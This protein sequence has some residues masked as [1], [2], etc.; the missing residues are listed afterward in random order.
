MLIKNG[1]IV[2]PLNKR[3]GKF[4]ILITGSKIKEIKK[5]IK[6]DDKE[7][8]DVEKKLVIP[9]LIDM[10]V[11]L[12]EPGREDI[13]TVESGT[14]AATSS[15]IT[16]LCAMPNTYPAMD[17]RENVKKLND[18]IEKDA[19]NN[20]FVIGA[21]TEKRQGKKL[22]DMKRMKSE[23]VV[24][25]SD[26][27]SSVE[28]K[29][30]MLE[31]LK[32]AE[33]NNLFLISHCEDKK[34]SKAGVVNEGIIAT[35]LG[36][37]GIPKKAEYKFVKR[38]I[39]LAKEANTRIHIAH[40]S[41]K[42]SVDIIRK[43][44]EEGIK[45]T[46]ETA[47]HYFSIDENAC[48]SYDTR[49]KMNPPLRSKEDL[50]AIKEALI[51]GTIDAI[52]SDH[53][54]HGKHEKE[55]EF[56]TAAFGIIGLETLLGLA[57]KLVDKKVL[58]WKR[59]VELTSVNPTKILGLKNKGSISVG[60]DADITVID[61]EKEWVFTKNSIRSKSKNSP[62]INWRFKGKVTDVIVGGKKVY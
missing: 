25:L 6:T 53:A 22:V 24:A 62:F 38:D 55:V 4:D 23:G 42:E 43:A 60:S 12:R 57:L 48:V 7:T 11:H 61:P 9:G 8:I 39:E 49:T 33:K 21:I 28:E 34:I 52:A 45:V 51:D 1:Y 15:G 36:L 26:D 5:E 35:K 50:E 30:V 31:A 56:D 14:V 37:R 29:S 59:L 58:S 16:S 54:P 18:I 13:E 20:V 10:H 17:S 46:A 47:P 44:K 3:E 32:E 40:V 2:D 19:K 41:C 27:G